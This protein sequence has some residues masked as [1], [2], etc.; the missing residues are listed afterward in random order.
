MSA[1]YY[2]GY[3]DDDY[4]MHH[5]TKGQKWG[6]RLYQNP[7]GSLTL[8]GR[9]HYGIGE[10]RRKYQTYKEERIRKG[11][12]KAVDRGDA[13]TLYKYRSRLSQQQLKEAV[14]RINMTQKL[15]DLTTASQK[16]K[17]QRDDIITTVTKIM[18]KSSKLLNAYTGLNEAIDKV[19]DLSSS[20]QDKKKLEKVKGSEE[21]KDIV[22]RARA[23]ANDAANSLRKDLAKSDLSREQIEAAVD[24]QYAKIYKQKMEGIQVSTSGVNLNYK[25]DKS[26]SKIIESLKNKK[27][28]DDSGPSDESGEKGKSKKKDK[29]ANQE[30]NKSESQPDTKSESTP[31]PAKSEQSKPGT[32]SERREKLFAKA[33]EY[34]KQKAYNASHGPKAVIRKAQASILSDKK[35]LAAEVAEQFS[36]DKAYRT[37]VNR[38]TGYDRRK[39][40]VDKALASYTK[41]KEAR[42]SVAAG[43]TALEEY[44]KKKN[45]K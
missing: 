29:Q 35:K 6:R 39:A 11:I 34:D 17:Q 18:D 30:P 26:V 4:L 44:R 45:K 16:A 22:K 9:A 1:I 10:A 33:D 15:S 28:N 27:E 31:E 40:M 7:D 19:R 25:E 32:I 36:K 3:N 5:G 12:E 43:R 37:L 14:E 13:D 21:Y 41:D 23:D 24:A 42:D 38:N 8:L 20:A 2:A